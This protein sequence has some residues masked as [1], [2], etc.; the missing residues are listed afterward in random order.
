MKSGGKRNADLS[1]IS[2][3]LNN[4][5]TFTQ[6]DLCIAFCLEN[7]EAVVAKSFLLLNTKTF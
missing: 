6:S 2:I 3:Y 4:L 7:C 1:R 5:N